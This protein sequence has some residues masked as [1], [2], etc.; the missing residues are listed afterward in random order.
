VTAS[1]PPQSPAAP[2]DLERLAQLEHNALA[3]KKRALVIVNPYATT[4][5]DRLRNLVVYALQARFEVDAVDTQSP[6]HATELCREAAHEG[7]DVMIAFGGDGT[8][9]E[10]A[11]G[12]AGTT[13]PMSCLPGGNTNVYCRL[14]GIPGEIVDATEHLLRITDDWQPRRVDLGRVNGRHFTF[15]SGVGIDASVVARVDAHPRLK[16]R[17]GPWY[18]TYVGLAVFSRRYLFK[19]PRLVTRIDEDTIEGV[20][21]IVQNASPYTYFRERPIAIADGATLDGGTLA[22]CVLRRGN[23]I[24][25]PTLVWRLLSGQPRAGGHR[26]VSEFDGARALKVASAD[27]RDLPLQVDGDYIGDVTEARYEIAPAALTVVA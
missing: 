17:F 14:L 18:F 6:G 24:D 3:P 20:T 2:S 21:T 10:V 4:V 12:L 1:S 13:T 26:H 25:M 8:V 15:S 7:Y 11:N 19:A 5:S 9:N 27:G 16:A 22:G 23:P